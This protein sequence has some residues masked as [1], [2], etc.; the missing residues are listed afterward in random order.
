MEDQKVFTGKTEAEVWKLVEADLNKEQDVY[1]YNAVI[2]QDGKKV[3]L[4]IEIDLG[5]GFEGGYEN[6]A[7]SAEIPDTKG[8]K[9]AVHRDGFIDDIG[10]FLGMQDVEVGYRDLDKH[11]IIK[12]NDETKVKALFDH[13]DVRDVFEK[14]D[15]FDFG[16]HMHSV[17]H[18][19]HRHAFL[20]LNI[21]EGI[22]EPD[23][24]RKLYSAFY[25]VLNTI[26]NFT[27]PTVSSD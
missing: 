11:L 25:R 21:E 4:I 3:D 13:K 15:D 26:D 14:L 9:F 20:E 23:E 2:N 5:G 8:F 17:E 19:D 12:T 22:T 10:K 27:E 7:F 18:S 1:D 6:T 16:I 24:L